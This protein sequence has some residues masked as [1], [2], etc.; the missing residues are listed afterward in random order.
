MKILSLFLSSVSLGLLSLQVDATPV[1]STVS[2][3]SVNRGSWRSVIMPK[4]DV[5]LSSQIEGL[6]MSFPKNEGDVVKVGDVLVQLDDRA[7]KIQLENAKASLRRSK[8]EWDKAQKDLERVQSLYN[9]KIASDKQLQEALVV[10]E[11]A[12]ANHLQAEQSVKMA[13]LQLSYRAIK[14]PIDGVFLKKTKSVGEAVQRLEVVARVVDDSV[15]ELV[16]YASAQYF[17]KIHIGDVV[18]VQLLDGPFA[19]EIIKGTVNYVDPLIDPASGTFR[20]KFHFV[21]ADMVYSGVGALV[22]PE[23]F[24]HLNHNA[25]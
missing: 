12:I 21:D 13:E 9:D 17:K 7:E 2:A 3:V 25:S 14:S 19:N 22:V 20:I 11:Q 5:R 18:D 23:T 6:V 24:N 8:A 1:P 10:L 16:T 15:L 4:D